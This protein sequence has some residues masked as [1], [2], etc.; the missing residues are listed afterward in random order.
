MRALEKPLLLVVL[1]GSLQVFAA[2]A[3]ATAQITASDI[4]DS[5]LEGP[6]ESD[7]T[8]PSAAVVKL[9]VL[10]DRAGASPGVIDGF[11]GENVSKAIAAFESMEGLAADGEID[12]DMLGRL[13]QA[14]PITQRYV[15]T[16]EDAADV[17]GTL[18]E[19]YSELAEL[20]FLGYET[21]A[22]KLAERF[23]MDEDLLAALNPGA[24]YA[25]GEEIVVVDPGP[26]VTGEVS[27]IEAD[28]GRRQVRA[29]AADGKLLAA[30]PATIG[31]T[32]NPSP[33]GTHAVAVVVL[34]PEYSY[35]PENFKQGDNEEPLTIP[36]GPN[37]P[38]GSVWIDLTEP[39]FGIHGTPKPSLID[40]TV[41]H[42][43]VRLTN[44]DAEEL[45]TL[46]SKGVPVAF[47][48]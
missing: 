6:L 13:P 1:V 47:I 17:V 16:A 5:V 41:S 20:E 21:V 4:E 45:S 22:E 37:G 44:W 29:Y 7:S 32:E 34:M 33:S 8:A 42:G 28:K 43:C 9:Q 18:P 27:R 3:T 31:S 10:L 48:E 14:G 39:T 40:K 2:G 46:V 19:D 30:Y 38:V 24:T 12:P 11:L 26:E 25:A 35:N 23:H 15:I 36:P